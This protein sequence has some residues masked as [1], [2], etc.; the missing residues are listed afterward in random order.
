[1]VLQMLKIA[2]GCCVRLRRT[3]RYFASVGCV[4]GFSHRYHQSTAPGQDE[5]AVHGRQV[6]CT[7]LAAGGIWSSLSSSYV[8][9]H[10]S[11]CIYL[12]ICV[13]MHALIRVCIF[14][15]IY[16]YLRMCICMYV[17]VHVF[18]YAY[19]CGY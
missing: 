10:V 15:Y 5:E 2:F 9:M 3:L 12:S 14:V 18:I 19:V 4:I 6:T 11:V 13:C 7:H 1:M 8:C 16:V 17:Y